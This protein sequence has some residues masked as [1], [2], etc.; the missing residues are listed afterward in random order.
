M[1]KRYSCL[2]GLLA[3][4]AVLGGVIYFTYKP[5]T[6]SIVLGL[7]IKGGVSVLLEAVASEGSP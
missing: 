2:I 4:I 5:L 1:E 3:I 7:D 6:D